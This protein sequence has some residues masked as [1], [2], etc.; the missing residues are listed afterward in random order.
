[1]GGMIAISATAQLTDLVRGGIYSA[2]ALM[3][4]PSQARLKSLASCLQAIFPKLPVSSL[5]ADALCHD[6]VVIEQY[7]YDT[8]LRNICQSSE[9]NDSYYHEQHCKMKAHINLHC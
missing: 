8:Y 4:D 2:P 3:I 7:Q 6:P 1:M 9:C 5:T